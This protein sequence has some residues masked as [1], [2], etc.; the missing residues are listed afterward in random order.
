MSKQRDQA[1]DNATSALNKEMQD[2]CNDFV[3][4]LQANAHASEHTVRAYERDI[5][6]CLGWLTQEGITSLYSVRIEDLRRWMAWQSAQCVRSTMARKTVAV[7]RFFAWCF[8]HGRI[9]SN[10]AS[11]LQTPKMGNAL[12]TV[13]NIEQANELVNFAEENAEKTAEC[14][15]KNSKVQSE[16]VDEVK[17]Y[18]VSLRDAAMLELLYATG[19]RVA[20]LV[21][22]DIADVN[23]THQLIKVTGK[24]NKQR[25]VPFGD[26]A[27]HALAAWLSDEGRQQLTG[28]SAVSALFVGVQ[29]KR[30]DQRVVRRVVHTAA[31]Q[32]GVPDI[33]PHAL[34][35]S[36]ATHML[37]GGAD[38]REVQEFLGHASLRTTQRYTHVSIEQLRES[39][40]QSFP[41]A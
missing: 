40:K 33:A 4:Y 13:L 25:Y 17:K 34:R 14:A 26:P 35:H 20:E 7:R 19:M 24:G 23:M 15:S 9:P 30:I 29:G 21:G 10:P 6:G 8:E 5:I 1:G 22:T 39:Y 2:A 41:R 27:R 28:S 32:S 12:P 11:R 31:Q 18:A 16:N 38:L 36:A 3:L 37:Q